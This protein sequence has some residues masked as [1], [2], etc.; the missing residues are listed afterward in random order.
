[1]QL[2]RLQDAERTP[3]LMT[4]VL[5]GGRVLIDRDGR[6]PQLCSER[7]AWDAKATRAE[8]PLQDATPELDL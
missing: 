5:E 1:M 7:H 8:V 6:W 2:V 4:D 3:V